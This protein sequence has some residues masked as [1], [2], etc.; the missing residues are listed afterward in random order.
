MDP[1]GEPIGQPVQPESRVGRRPDQVRRCRIV[2]RA[3]LSQVAAA[4]ESRPHARQENWTT[5][6]GSGERPEGFD[7]GVAHGRGIGVSESWAVQRQRHGVAFGVHEDRG[8]RLVGPD[9]SPPCLQPAGELVTGLQSAVGRRLQQQSGGR[10]QTLA[11]SQDLAAGQSGL[12]RGGHQ[13]G[14]RS[15]IDGVVGQYVKGGGGPWGGQPDR[16]DRQAV[17][18]GGGLRWQEVGVGDDQ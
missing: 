17:Q 16:D 1:H 3:E 4:G 7:E 2:D 14:D 18:R 12:W 8:F 11:V 9:S 15:G 5:V 6:S 13:V 10:V